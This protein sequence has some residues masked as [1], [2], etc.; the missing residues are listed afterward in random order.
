M[1]NDKKWAAIIVG[2]PGSGKDTQAEL[3]AR[4]LRLTEIKTSDIINDKFAQADP[5]NPFMQEQIARKKAGELVD[6]K[7]VERWVEEAVHTAAA[8]DTGI[9]LTGSPR[10]LEEAQVI[11]PILDN[12]YDKNTIKVVLITLS[13]EES[14][15]RNSK[16]RVCQANG[17]PIWDTEQNKD[18]TACPEDGSPI[19]LRGD[20]TPETIINRYQVY[21]RETAPVLDW[22]KSQGYNI[23]T[24][25]GEQS[26]EDVHRDMLNSLW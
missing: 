21:L 20:D 1:T 6:S 8:G 3:L 22:L 4:E 15:K 5:N 2:P 26:I 11:M 16:R 17:H 24:V 13:E 23:A 9:V 25:N 18:L 14:V 12:L 19:I 7:I 10:T